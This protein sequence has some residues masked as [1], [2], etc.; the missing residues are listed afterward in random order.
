MAHRRLQELDDALR[1]HRQPEK[2]LAQTRHDDVVP[3]AYTSPCRGSSR[4]R[5]R[6]TGEQTARP[7]FVCLGELS[8]A[9]PGF[10]W[11]FGQ[12]AMT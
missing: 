6:L 12:V 5:L 1:R 11:P 8:R 7:L 2:L 3:W 4:I 10:S 9:A